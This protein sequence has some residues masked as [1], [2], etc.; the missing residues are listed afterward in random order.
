[1]FRNSTGLTTAFATMGLGVMLALPAHAVDE[2]G[3]GSLRVEAPADA[4]L[5]AAAANRVSVV[6]A[7]VKQAIT[8]RI[9]ERL[10]AA[11]IKVEVELDRIELAS[12]YDAMQG[13][14][15]SVLSGQV[16]LRDVMN[17]PQHKSFAVTAEAR[18][19]NTPTPLGADPTS[20]VTVLPASSEQFYDAMV[21]AFALGVTQ[22][23]DQLP[24]PQP[25]P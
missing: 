1:M 13:R 11:G 24:A 6:D 12:A 10:A 19:V 7:D 25:L 23:I 20:D 5:G 3:V 18:Q 4:A 17:V 21:E 16:Q 8:T 15:V 2:R 9:E 22:T 14:D